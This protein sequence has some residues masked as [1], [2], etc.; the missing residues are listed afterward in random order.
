MPASLDARIVSVKK[1]VIVRNMIDRVEQI[2]QLAGVKRSIEE[3]IKEVWERLDCDFLKSY[4]QSVYYS[5][6]SSAYLLSL[7]RDLEEEKER[8]KNG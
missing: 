8:R 7:L 4:I 1:R 5:N 6:D 2:H 3:T